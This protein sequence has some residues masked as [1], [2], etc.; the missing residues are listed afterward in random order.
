MRPVLVRSVS[1]AVALAALAHAHEADADER[2]KCAESAEEGQTKRDEGNL[3]AARELFVACARATCPATV[4][5]SCAGWL[6]DLETRIPTIAPS[7]RDAEGHDVLGARLVLDG[8][9][10][11]GVLDG[12]AFAVNPGR[13]ELTAIAPSGAR[14]STP[15]LVLEGERA[16]PVRLT[17]PPPPHPP[18]PPDRPDRADPAPAPATG[19]GVPLWPALAFGAVSVAGFVTFGVLDSGARADYRDYEGSCSPNCSADK[20]SSLRTKVTLSEVGLGV[21]IGAAVLAAGWTVLHLVTR[22]SPPPARAATPFVVRF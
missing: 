5:R 9:E 21:G 1:L 2:V 11:K 14:V 8:I 15:V 7:L 3:L 20:L 6:V 12:T 13:H 17:L 10:R 16:R 18:P 22:S 19:T 4:Q